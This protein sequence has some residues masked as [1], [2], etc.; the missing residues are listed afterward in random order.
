[1]L[2]IAV[3]GMGGDLAPEAAVEGAVLA[4]SELDVEVVL[5]GQEEVLKQELQKRTVTRG[6]L[7]IEHAPEYVDMAESPVL[8]V[9]K[10]KKSSIAVGLELMKNRE[11][12]AFISA[13]NTGAVVAAST[14]KL[15]C[16]PGIKRPGIA[17]SVPT[18]RG[19]TLML[20]V[21]ANIDPKPEHLLQ[22][23]I[24]G[25]I[26]ARY[27]HK[28]KRPSIG[29]LNIGEEESKGTE[30]IKDAYKLLRDSDVT[31]VGNVEGRDIFSGK[32][33]C[34]ICDGFVGNV[35]LKVIESIADTTIQV[36]KKELNKNLVTKMG[37]LFLKAALS[38]WQKET[39]ASEFGG[40]PLLGVD[41]AVF[42]SHGSSNA[43]AIKNAIRTA[44]QA[45]Q[46]D[47]NGQIV[48]EI[49]KRNKEVSNNNGVN[50][51]E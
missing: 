7:F 51:T 31:F 26:Y 46:Y 40:A 30:L 13:G 23:G 24:M 32:T 17:I 9:K 36:L 3:D 5:V 27:I 1:M 35:V 28:K 47:I 18:L 2:K 14:L 29:L 25:D 42:I 11:V 44:K 33:D 4:A 43:V 38:S 15:G 16:L 37:G 12:N 50:E 10:K 49:E 19:V 8:A 20:D 34:I 22:Y 41:G 39:D 45:V 48:R 6:R 21:G